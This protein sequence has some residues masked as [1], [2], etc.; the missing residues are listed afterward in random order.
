MEDFIEKWTGKLVEAAGGAL[1][2]SA[3]RALVQE[4]YNSAA[5]R[6]VSSYEEEV[7][8]REAEREE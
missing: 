5:L 4:I 7:A 1:D 3:A 2:E 8:I 6:E